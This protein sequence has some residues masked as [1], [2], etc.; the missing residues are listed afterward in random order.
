M[1]TE[2][3]GKQGSFVLNCEVC[4][5]S[6]IIAQVA[7]SPHAHEVLCVARLMGIIMTLLEFLL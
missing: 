6:V 1:G 3:Q 4:E 5:Q 7:L 2:D